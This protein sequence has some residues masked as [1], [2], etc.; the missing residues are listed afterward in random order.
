MIRVRRAVTGVASAALLALQLVGATSA[1]QAAPSMP[2]PGA[3]VRIDSGTAHAKALG[4]HRYRISLPAQPNV[5]WMGTPPEGGA[6]PVGSL[7]PQDVA[8]AWTALGHRANVGVPTRIT[9]KE[10]GADWTDFRSGFVT[11]PRIGK[12]GRLAF[13][14]RTVR[15]GLPAALPNFSLNISPADPQ[16]RTTYPATFIV[17]IYG[18]TNMALSITATSKTAATMS[19]V[20][21][22]STGA[23]GTCPG[24][25]SPL[26]SMSGTTRKDYYYGPVVCSNVTIE[27]GDPSYLGWHPGKTGV[28]TEIIPCYR[29]EVPTG[30]QGI[31]FC[32]DTITLD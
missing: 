4:N 28:S 14:M 22:D 23:W 5:Q 1:A 29:E 31:S 20:I 3:I 21:K 18:T 17:G 9:W 16:P 27:A 7:K 19:F 11:N 12:D 10:A 26:V 24:T 2:T 25:T 6:A 8:K 30:N 32:A 15:G 13:T